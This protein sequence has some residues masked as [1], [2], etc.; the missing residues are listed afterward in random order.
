[1]EKPNRL[2]DAP[3]LLEAALEPLE[4][5]TTL[6][7]EAEKA[8]RAFFREGQSANTART[9]KTA[10]QYWGA[11]HALRFGSAIEGPVS[12]SIAVQFIVDH[13]QHQPGLADPQ[14]SPYTPSSKSTQ[15]LLPLAIDRL[16]VERKYKARIGPW[17]IAT[18]HTRLAA[19]SKAHDNYIANNPLLNLGPEINPMRDPRVRQLIAAAR[20][21]YAR[22]G[23]IPVRPVAA[24]RGV[25]T[26][27]LATCGEDL[28]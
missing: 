19:L 26:A 24:T 23:R 25:M 5:A 18:V 21:A 27:L 9:Y 3:L 11:W 17:S 22:R 4:D 2:T 1:M 13:L 8:V 16:L 15:H 12:A 6:F 7:V 28:I 10:L 14:I 20:R